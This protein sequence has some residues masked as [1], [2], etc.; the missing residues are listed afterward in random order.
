MI[1][2]SILIIRSLHNCIYW[3]CLLAITTINA[4]GHVNII[5]R[6][7]SWA[8]RSWCTLNCNCKGRAS[9]CTQFASNTSLLSCCISS[10]SMLT[11]KFRR[12]WSFLIWI[13]DSPLRLKCVKKPTIKEWIVEVRWNNLD[14]L[15]NT[16]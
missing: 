4:F 5:S 8:I 6:C 10:Q 11:S 15:K 3:T 1:H 12:N 16:L 13:M 7:S 14:K 2:C 9:S